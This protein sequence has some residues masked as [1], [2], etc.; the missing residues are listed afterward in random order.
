MS[1][2]P[3]A[4]L[5]LVH[6]FTPGMYIR[7]IEIPASTLLTSMEHA[8]EHPF[9]ILSG[10]VDVISDFEEIQYVGPCIGITK[11]GTKRILFTHTD[12]VWVTFHANPENFQN[13]EEIGERILAPASNPFFENK[14]DPAI[15]LWK[16]SPERQTI[17]T[18]QPLETKL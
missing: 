10:T 16:H 9:V 7:Q 6:L 2:M 4:V 14:D 5:P 3:P 12:T 18:N 15:N 13:H 17:T 8:T 11:P 1:K